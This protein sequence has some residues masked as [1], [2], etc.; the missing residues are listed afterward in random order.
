MARCKLVAMSKSVS[1]MISAVLFSLLT[2]VIEEQSES[3]LGQQFIWQGR[4]LFSIVLSLK[5][6]SIAA[7][8]LCLPWLSCEQARHHLVCTHGCS[9]PD[10]S[11]T[12]IWMIRLQ[13]WH[14]CQQARRICSCA[15]Y[16]RA[17]TKPA[18]FCTAA[19][20]LDSFIS[21]QHLIP[22]NFDMAYNTSFS[23]RFRLKV[24]G[25]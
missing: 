18:A 20:L 23:D 2:V 25:S 14:L 12:L 8:E 22:T 19:Y 15:C 13:A 11:W 6:P 7:V 9:S 3:C 17:L 1:Y 4:T 24:F 5:Q 10:A 16:N 21:T